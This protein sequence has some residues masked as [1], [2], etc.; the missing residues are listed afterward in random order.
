MQAQLEALV[1]LA[2]N[3]GLLTG[4]LDATVESYDAR[5]TFKGPKGPGPRVMATFRP[6]D[7]NDQFIAGAERRFDVT[8]QIVAMGKEKALEIEDHSY[9]AD[10]LY[11]GQDHFEWDGPFE[12][13][14]EDAIREFYGED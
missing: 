6:Q 10:C 13:E 2:V 11:H 1:D 14:A 8:D 4:D 3:R 9:S 12:V 7:A 5:V